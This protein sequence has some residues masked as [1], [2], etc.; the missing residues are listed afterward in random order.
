MQGLR[1]LRSEAYIRY[2]A[3]KKDERNAAD[4]LL[5]DS[6]DEVYEAMV[7]LPFHPHGLPPLAKVFE[8]Q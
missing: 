5:P 4:G 8:G 3:V 1:I 7:L 6:S 2:A